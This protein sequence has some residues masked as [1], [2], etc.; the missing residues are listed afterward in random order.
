[1]YHRAYARLH[2]G[3]EQKSLGDPRLAFQK[4][5]IVLLYFDLFGF[6][7]LLQMRGSCD[8]RE[9]RVPDAG[10]QFPQR[11]DPNAF[12][13][14]LSRARKTWLDVHGPLVGDF[15]ILDIDG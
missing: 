14:Q 12:L 6:S 1:M 2:A 4:N 7:G 5:P 3:S 11:C 8:A 15:P 10:N 13:V 9:C